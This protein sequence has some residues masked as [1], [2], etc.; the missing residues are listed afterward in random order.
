[1][2]KKARIANGELKAKVHQLERE[3]GKY[4]HLKELAK[5]FVPKQYDNPDYQFMKIDNEMTNMRKEMKRIEEKWK[6]KVEAIDR[7]Y[8]SFKDIKQHKVAEVEALE[9]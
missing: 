3:V 4:H 7:E 2:Y 1:M 5:S 9:K 6:S 8:F